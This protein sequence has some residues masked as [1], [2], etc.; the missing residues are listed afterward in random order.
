MSSEKLMEAA[1]TIVAAMV[2][3]GLLSTQD[4]VLEAIAKIKEALAR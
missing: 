3:A 4:E 1:A 2:I